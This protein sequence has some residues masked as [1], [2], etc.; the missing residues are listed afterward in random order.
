MKSTCDQRFWN[1]ANRMMGTVTLKQIPKSPVQNVRYNFRWL[2]NNFC[3]ISSDVR[4]A[5]PLPH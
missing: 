5:E 3:T 1:G 2:D 4:A